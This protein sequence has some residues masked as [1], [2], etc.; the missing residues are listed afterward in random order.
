MGTSCHINSIVVVFKAVAFITAEVKIKLSRP[1]LI[2]T[3]FSRNASRFNKRG[4]VDLALTVQT[5][6]LME[7]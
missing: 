2:E 3:T 1:V 4:S 5:L 6:Y 7:R